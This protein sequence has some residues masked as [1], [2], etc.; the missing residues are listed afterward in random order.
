M[1]FA[2]LFTDRPDQG[3]LRAEHLQALAEHLL[4]P[5]DLQRHRGLAA[6]QPL[7]GAGQVQLDHFRRAAAHQEHLLVDALVGA[8]ALE[9]RRSVGAEQQQGRHGGG[10]GGPGFDPR[11]FF[12]EFG[13]GFKSIEER[14]DFDCVKDF[15]I[16]RR[17]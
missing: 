5:L 1:L 14:K 4:Q 10:P 7:G 3:A 2:V 15:G 11:F 13:F 6:Q 9:P 17:W 12:K 16:N 8:A